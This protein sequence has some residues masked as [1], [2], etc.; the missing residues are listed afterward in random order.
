MTSTPLIPSS[1]TP[2]SWQPNPTKTATTDT[3][4]IYTTRWNN[5]TS[6]EVVQ[7]LL[8]FGGVEFAG[9]TYSNSYHNTLVTT[10]A[11]GCED[12]HMATPIGNK[13]GGHTFKIGYIPEGSTTESFNFAGCNASGCHSGSAITATSAKW[14][15]VRNEIIAKTAKLAN[16]CLDTTRTKKWTVPKS[17][18]TVQWV[19]F[20]ISG[21]DTTWSVANA[22]GTSPLQIVPAYKAGVLWNLQ[23]A[24]YENSKGI[25]NTAYIRSLLDASIA[26]MEKP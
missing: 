16:Y 19:S 1:S 20:T 21:A 17:G 22:S 26:E 23:Q 10:K 8:G 11:I 2:A 15:G 25:H 24:M 5:H 12:C 13:G 18:K 4:K 7:T 3:A 6:G 14:A 9:Y